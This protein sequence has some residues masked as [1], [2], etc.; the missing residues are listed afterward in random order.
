MRSSRGVPILSIS[1]ARLI[2]RI[3]PPDIDRDRPLVGEPAKED[4]NDEEV[5]VYDYLR[6]GYR[7][8]SDRPHGQTTTYL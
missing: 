1:D 2:V 8:W 5:I 7:D 3:L 4:L 6:V